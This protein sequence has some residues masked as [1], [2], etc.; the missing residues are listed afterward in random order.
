[1]KIARYISSHIVLK[2]WPQQHRQRIAKYCNCKLGF[3]VDIILRMHD[4][5]SMKWRCRTASGYKIFYFNLAS[6]WNVY[7]TRASAGHEPEGCS[8]N[9]AHSRSFNHQGFYKCLTAQIFTLKACITQRLT[10]YRHLCV[11]QRIASNFI[12]RC[13]WRPY[14]KHIVIVYHYTSTISAEQFHALYF[15]SSSKMKLLYWKRVLYSV[16]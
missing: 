9:W 10:L 5:K 4:C 11:T 13:K 12:S 2:E 8:Q 15:N 7:L 6:Y 1:M 16:P 14:C 3:C